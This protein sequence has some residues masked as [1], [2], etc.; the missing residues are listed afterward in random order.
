MSRIQDLQQ[1][2]R[3][4]DAET[5]ELVSRNTQLTDAIGSAASMKLD[6]VLSQTLPAMPAFAPVED[7]RQNYT[8]AKLAL[9]EV[10]VDHGPKHPRT[11]AAQTTLDAARAAA[12]PALRR[13]R[14]A[15]ASEQAKIAAALSRQQTERAELDR[16]M[17]EMGDAPANLARLEAALEEARSTYIRSSDAAGTFSPAPRQSAAIAQAAKP[18]LAN[19]D[20]FTAKSMALAGGA[21]GLLMSLL[22][23]SFR[24]KDND[25]IEQVELADTIEP[26]VAETHEE[27]DLAAAQ[28]VEIEPGIFDDVMTVRHEPEPVIEQHIAKPEDAELEDDGL[29][30]HDEPANDMPL[31]QRVRQVLMRNAV[32]L[33]QTQRDAPVFKLPPL[34]AAALAG[35]AE[36]RQAE[37]E[38]LRALRQELVVIRERLYRLAEEERDSRRA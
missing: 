21:A 6:D 2:I 15:L 7:I 12:M 20:S 25:D 3:E 4:D 28:P 9:A 16:Q 22:V 13:V 10:S 31:D 38:D 36:H 14:E 19:Y 24:R 34:L 1:K 17:Q 23:L 18:G 5:E 32:P 26:E 30:V 33:A 8:A 35:E 11:I 27:V 29:T 37:T